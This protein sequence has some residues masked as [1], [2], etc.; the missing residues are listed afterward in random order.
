MLTRRRFLD[1]GTASL[2]AAAGARPAGAG[3]RRWL[4]DVHSGLNRTMVRAVHRPGSLAQLQAVIRAA[5]R[6]G[7]ELSIAGGRHAM[8]GQQFGAATCSST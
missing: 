8:G 2:V 6:T 5:G 7:H 1:L 4:N 3:P